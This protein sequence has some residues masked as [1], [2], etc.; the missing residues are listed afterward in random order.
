MTNNKITKHSTFKRSVHTET[1]IN[2]PIEKVWQELTY[3][4]EM[5]TWSKSLQKIE[6]DFRKNGQTEVYFMDNK[7]KVG[8]YK[9]ELIHFEEGKLFGWS[10]PFILGITDNHKYQLEKISESQ[11]KLI[12][13]DEANGFATLIMGNFIMNFFLKS[14]LEFND[15]LKA[16]IEK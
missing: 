2:A 13:S 15:I 5:P 3:F 11:T 14:Y 4:K 9:H 12:Q 10:D 16:R 1:I 7:G 8:I 6:G